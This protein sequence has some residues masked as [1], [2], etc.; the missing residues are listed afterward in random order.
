MKL[1]VKLTINLGKDEP[2]ASVVGPDTEAQIGTYHESGSPDMYLGFTNGM[3]EQ[4]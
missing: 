2:A 1:T 3:E 4:R